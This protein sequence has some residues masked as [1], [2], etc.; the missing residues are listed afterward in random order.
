MR[1][2]QN[3]VF[4]ILESWGRDGNSED[5]PQI[6]LFSNITAAK[7]HLKELVAIDRESGIHFSYDPEDPDDDWEIV[8]KEDLFYAWSESA[9]SW[10]MF[11]IIEKI[12]HETAG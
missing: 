10:I 12:I 11:K 9:N 5:S 7:E 3:T 2:K 6:T 1:E 4:A 8:N